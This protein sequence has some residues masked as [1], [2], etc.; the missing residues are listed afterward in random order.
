VID[1]A[2][3]FELSVVAEGIEDDATYKDLKKFGC[4]MAQGFLISKA[5]PFDQLTD[6]L[7]AKGR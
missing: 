4:D 1:L 3:N 6:W 2:H 7:K 5:L